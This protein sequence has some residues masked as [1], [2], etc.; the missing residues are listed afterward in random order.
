MKYLKTIVVL[1]L[2]AVLNGCSAFHSGDSRGYSDPHQ[3]EYGRSDRMEYTQKRR[4]ITIAVERLLT[5]PMFT[6]NYKAV[7]K[8]VKDAHRIMP[9][10][11]VNVIENNTGDGRSDS[12]ATGQIYREL[13]T[14][15]RK[16]GRF[17]M[18]DRV[19]RKQMRDANIKGVDDGETPIGLQSI[20]EY[21]S[22]DFLI[23]GDLRR[24]ITEGVNRKV[25]HHILNLEMINS[26]TGTVFWSESI[27]VSK[28]EAK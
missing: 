9:T 13:I 2:L 15:I 5:D 19:R 8:R 23:T 24:E 11:A 28:F 21:A 1:S 6:D 27:P 7:C 18:I 14:A 3:D 10:I 12:E 26:Y 25:Y 20:G 16:T 4:A 17:E 22:A